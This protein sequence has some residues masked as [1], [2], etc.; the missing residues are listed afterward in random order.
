MKPNETPENSHQI[1]RRDMLK[2]LGATAAS[3]A[4]VGTEPSVQAAA[5]QA[6]SRAMPTNPYGS[7]MPFGGISLPDYY[8]PTPYVRNRNNFVPGEPIGPDEMRIFFLGST[9]WPPQRNQA[10]T[11]IMVELGNGKRFF[12]DFGNGATRNYFAL[13][14][15]IQL[16]NDIFLSHLHVDHYADLPYLLP[17]SAFQGRYKPLRVHGPSGRTPELGTRAMIKGMKEMLRWHL[18]AFDV[19]PIGEGYEVEVNEFDWRDDGGVC[20]DKDGVKVIHWRRSH[21]KDGAS[22]YRLDWNGLSFVW[23]GDGRPDELTLKYAKGVDVYVSEGQPDTMG[24]FALKYGI[25]AELS[26]LV[27]DLHHTPFYAAGYM[28]QQIKPRIAQITHF[29]FDESLLQE[30][31]A[32][33]RAHYDGLFVYGG[34]DIMVTNVTRDAIWTRKAYMPEHTGNNMPTP[35]QLAG[36][37][38]IDP[39]NPPKTFVFPEPKLPR[40]MQQEQQTRANEIDPKKYYPPTINRPI[41]TSWPKG[42]SLDLEAMAKAR[43]APQK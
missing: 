20:Y 42:F 8:R 13:G 12:F 41:L 33:I 2:T 6:D 23:T 35:E 18:E 30:M 22:A 17:F 37:F 28:F 24:M 11:C 10:S 36:A 16:V 3:L 27:V 5:Q 40:E 32:Q 43:Q 31:S 1:S 9:P 25:P 21:A 7:K 19:V 14:L 34:P 39:K 15:P 26:A 4:V 29:D 38:G